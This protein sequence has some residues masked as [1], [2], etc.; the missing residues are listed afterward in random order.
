MTEPVPRPQALQQLTIPGEIRD[1]MLQ[2]I[3]TASGQVWRRPGLPPAQRSLI[4]IAVLASLGRLEL[5][6]A[7]VGL[8]LD[9]GLSSLEICEAIMHTAIY[10]GFPAAVT[11]F[12]VADAV[13]AARA[14]AGGSGAG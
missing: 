4:T 8:G 13:F 3:S 1:D 14:E 11:A 5:V 2:L 10:A 6:R 7:H 12:E 9:N